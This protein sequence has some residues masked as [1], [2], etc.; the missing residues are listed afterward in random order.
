MSSAQHNFKKPFRRTLGTP[1]LLGISKEEN[2]LVGRKGLKIGDREDFGEPFAEGLRLKLGPLT[3]DGI[4]DFTD[5]F[6]DIIRGH[7]DIP[8]TRLKRINSDLHKTNGLDSPE[9]Q[10]RILEW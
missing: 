8:S 5:V 2:K 4:Q 10:C 3:D 7:R 9:V 6:L 1:I